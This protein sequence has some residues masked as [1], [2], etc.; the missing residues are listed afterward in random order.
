MAARQRTT[1]SKMIDV[2]QWHDDAVQVRRLGWS[3]ASTGLRGSATPRSFHGGLASG[4]P[5]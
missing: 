4:D 5:G 3:A 2:T 1:V